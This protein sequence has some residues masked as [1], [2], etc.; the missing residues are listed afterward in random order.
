M[1]EQSYHLLHSLCGCPWTPQ[2]LPKVC[3]VAGLPEA[4]AR[5]ILTDLE[6]HGYVHQLQPISQAAPLEVH[7]TPL[8][9]E[10]VLRHES[11][12]EPSP[13]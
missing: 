9:V 1:G 3:T 7:I 12:A 11:A 10:Y 6:G 4:E 5:A 8:G 2:A 13:I